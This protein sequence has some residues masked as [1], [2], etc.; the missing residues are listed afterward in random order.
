MRYLLALPLVLLLAIV[1]QAS[2]ES[3]ADE[4]RTA[5]KEAADEEKCV[6][7][8]AS[9]RT[10]PPCHCL[11][12]PVYDFPGP[13]DLYYCFT[14]LNLG[15]CTT[16]HGE[17][18]YGKPANP[19][20]PQVCEWNQCERYMGFREG[21]AV[22]IPG[23]EMSLTSA[24]AKSLAE[25]TKNPDLKWGNPEFHKIKP[26]KIAMARG[27]NPEMLIMAVP[28]DLPV[29][30]S[31]E[32]TNG[33]DSAA[34][35]GTDDSPLEQETKTYY[36]CMQIDSLDKDQET[37]AVLKNS[38]PLTGRQFKIQYTV[39]GKEREGHVWLKH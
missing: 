15:D 33:T 25:A 35:K 39:E 27:T 37:T 16:C 9:W 18:W 29:P 34:A 11:Q 14:Y 36:I 24:Q 1:W 23:H 6:S 38:K 19:F 12:E 22:R 28:V 10:M 7:C 13:Y 21:D 5:A 30:P 4:S 31:V 17:L 20:Y 32:D 8:G 2:A 3:S 26:T